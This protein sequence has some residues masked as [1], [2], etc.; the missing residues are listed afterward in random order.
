MTR[1]PHEEKKPNSLTSNTAPLEDGSVD[2]A[3]E[4]RILR[5][6]DLHLMVPLW[7]LFLISFMD[8][9]NLGNVAVLGITKDLRL[10]GDDFNI[11]LQVFFVPYI[12]LE[13]PSNLM[14]KRISPSLWLCALTLLWGV[15]CMCQGFV[16]NLGGLVACRFF[17]GVFEAGFVPGC[18]YLM[19]S[20]YKR[21]EL[22]RRF[23]LFWCAG[24]VAGAFSGLL[25]YALEHMG[26][27]SG[28]AGWRW[29]LIIEGL[30]SIA[31]SVPAY[32]FLADW[33]Q[34]AKFLSPTAKEVL[35]Q[36]HAADLGGHS[37]MDRLDKSALRRILLDWKIWCGAV[38]YIC[39][40]VSGYATALFVPTI[41]ASLGY[42]G[43]ESQIH[44]IPVW[45]VAAVVTLCT[46]VF[47][48]RLQHRYTFVM[49]G[50]FLSSIGYIILLKQGPLAKPHRPQL[51]LSP[52]VRYMAVF[53]VTCGTYIVQPLIIVWLANNLGGH[54]KRAIGLAVQISLGNIGGII[55]SNVFVK[56]EAPR[57]FIG[58]GVGLAT[59]ISCGVVS[60]IFAWGLLRENKKR[61]RGE[62]D[63]RL[64]LSETERSNLGDDDPS[65]KFAL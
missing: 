58:Y 13:V 41:L 2:S 36:R 9:I 7:I 6:V 22:Q 34:Q 59:M 25:A 8:R 11:A 29:I 28:L 37:K 19:S 43:I 12:L 27:L 33:P 26:G 4:K 44:S 30:L 35:A 20:Y 64:A 3:L 50:V 60:S 10:V 24:L 51:G 42:S 21:H 47:T 14:L 48:D 63:D 17:V 62:R 56:T 32:W 65:F 45:M 39:I 49:F 1:S 23:S 40:T 46:A 5:N 54:Y 52:N 55:A 31:A 61:A 57:Y 15:A 38:M 18:A 53:F 16:H